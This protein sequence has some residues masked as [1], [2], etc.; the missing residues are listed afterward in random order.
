MKFKIAILLCSFHILI[1]F[2]GIPAFADIAMVL[3]RIE[4][5][6]CDDYKTHPLTEE[7]ISVLTEKISS[8]KSSA[9]K[10]AGHYFTKGDYDKSFPLYVKCSEKGDLQ[11]WLMVGISY[12]NGRGVK[13]DKRKGGDWV[14]KSAVEEHPIA[15]YLYGT[16]ID[17]G[18]GAKRVPKDAELCFNE[19]ENRGVTEETI[20]YHAKYTQAMARAGYGMYGVFGNT[21]KQLTSNTIPIIKPEAYDRKLN[22]TPEL[23]ALLEFIDKEYGKKELLEQKFGKPQKNTFEEGLTDGSRVDFKRQIL[24]YDGFKAVFIDIGK[25]F[26]L[27]RFVVSSNSEISFNGLRIGGSLDDLLILCGSGDFV[28][29][30]GANLIICDESGSLDFAEFKTK[31]DKVI[32]M[33]MYRVF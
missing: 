5:R 1:T 12:L 29:V 9:M 28:F 27:E 4:Q 17:E 11:A 2:L 23:K 13:Q 24:F 30:E 8:D 21:S 33:K 15:L 6:Y 22:P 10:L 32:E 19:A 25:G 3:H 26:E 14:W 31:N 18:Y 16:M 7:E 20:I